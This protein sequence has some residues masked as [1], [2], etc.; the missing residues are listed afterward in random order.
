MNSAF[1]DTTIAFVTDTIVAEGGSGTGIDFDACILYYL[2]V[3]SG[4]GGCFFLVGITGN[5]FTLAI[6]SKERKK[7]STIN[8]LFMLAI[9][10]SCVLISYS[11][12]IPVGIRKYVGGWFSGHNFNHI[13]F[14]YVKEAAR[15][16]NQVSAF[17][18][19]LVTF[20]RYVS[21]C[22]PHRAKQLCSV[23]LVNKLTAA[24][25]LFSAIFYLPQF[26]YYTLE[27]NEFGRYYSVSRSFVANQVFQ[28]IYSAILTLLISYVIPV[29]TL[30]FMCIRILRVM[31]QQG[32]LFQQSDERSRTRRDL[33]ISSIAIVILFVVC[34][35]FTYA[36]RV[37]M[38]IYNPF[39]KYSRCGGVLQTYSFV[40]HIAL[41]FNSAANFVIYICFAKAF[42][43]KLFGIF[44][45]SSK[46]APM[47]E[48]IEGRIFSVTTA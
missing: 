21:V 14:V 5:A 48:S 17:I 38:W 34:Q 24:S 41:M 43:K 7:S 27:K 1:D 46:V 44:C 31:H 19:M 26:L 8:S 42:R 4:I 18:T 16:F 36:T 23:S 30:I 2:I 47:K 12:L 35:S 25:F 3:G 15:V 33:T 6:M 28:V 37:L 11:Y 22:L 13:A 39:Y 40:P 10:D 45:K 32:K 29:S 9:A 20:Q